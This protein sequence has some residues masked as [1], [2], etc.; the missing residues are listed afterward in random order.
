MQCS[1]YLYD[2]ASET[3][4]NITKNDPRIPKKDGQIE[5]AYLNKL[6]EIG[7]TISG[8]KRKLFYLSSIN[9]N[10]H[11]QSFKAISC[12][13]NADDRP[14]INAFYLALEQAKFQFLAS[15]ANENEAK[16]SF[17]IACQTAITDA[18]PILEKHL[19]WGDAIAKFIVELLA[20][21]S[22]GLTTRW[23]LFV[24]RS[25]AEQEAETLHAKLAFDNQ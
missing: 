15:N 17:I 5:K 24:P 19:S 4:F 9:F 11:L 21:V 23:G 16:N 13:I 2:E 6:N 20:Y 1:S 25:S 7:E 8:W 3:L 14:N 18:T 22:F 12:S 10:D